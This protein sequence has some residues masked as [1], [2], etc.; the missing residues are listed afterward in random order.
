MNFVLGYELSPA[1][2]NFVK[3][4]GILDIVAE[5]L[6]AFFVEKWNSRYPMFNWK[7]NAASGSRL[8]DKIAKGFREARQNKDYIAK[9]RAGDEK[10]W[11]ITVVCKVLLDCGLS[12]IQHC[13][14]TENR[15]DSL[16]PSEEIDNIRKIRNG[17]FAH[18]SQ[19]SCSD[20]DFTAT[21]A[22]IKSVT[23]SLFGENVERKISG[24]EKFPIDKTI[25][26]SDNLNKQEDRQ[27]GK[28]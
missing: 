10:Q 1:K 6:R 26:L 28:R 12:L 9:M 5:N 24:I 21:V 20:D 22:E 17:F 27:L 11:D 19:F 25:E 15:S 2:E 3:L 23:R 4:T 13:R 14:P 7:S 8:Y 16:L 18:L